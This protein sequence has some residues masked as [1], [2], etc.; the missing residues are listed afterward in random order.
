LR[1]EAS[2]LAALGVALSALVSGCTGELKGEAI[3]GGGATT[4]TTGGS[5]SA[6]TAGTTAGTG[7]SGTSGGGGTTSTGGTGSGANAGSGGMIDPD[8]PTPPPPAN[9]GMVTARRLN[10]IEYNNT[11]HD[12]LG[13][14]MRPA[15]TFQADGIGAGF[16]TV[17]GA[18]SMS[19]TAVRDYEDAAYELVDELIADTARYSMIV[20]CDVTVQGEACMRTALEGLARKAYRRPVTT[21][22]ID[23]LLTPYRTAIML[24][25]APTLGL[26]YSLAAVLVNQNFLFKLEIDPDPMSVTPRRLNDYEIATRLSYAL[27]STMPDA[28]LFAAAEAGTLQ[29]DAELTRQVDRMLADTR[30]AAFSANFAGQWLEFRDTNHDPDTR[31][32]PMYTP[33]LAASMKQEAERFFA[34]FMASETP[35]SQLLSARFTYVDTGLANHYGLPVQTGMQPGQMWRADTT[36]AE[37]SGLLTLGAVLT[38]TSLTTRTSPVKRGEFVLRRLMCQTVMQPPPDVIGIPDE[39]D[40]NQGQLTMR[41]R[42]EQHRNN[43]ACIGCHLDMDQL[44][45]GLENYDAVG[46]YRTTDNNLPVDSAGELP[47]GSTF[48]G[49][50]ELAELLSRDSRFN[51]CLARNIMTYALGRYLDQR[52][53]QTWVAYVAG[54][55]RD[56]GGKLGTLIRTL[57]KSES[58]RSRQAIVAP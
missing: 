53:D 33:A 32:F 55:T 10:R 54:T 4:S 56:Q 47:D 9:P 13:T 21:A 22:E 31:V 45:F 19:P 23:T 36:G 58:F 37:R 1:L 29:T 40:P 42:M 8:A 50:V 52:D 24:G 7:T 14:S 30:A 48:T 20:P 26:R 35:A 51:T 17:G 57:L 27:W 25:A 15:D 44:G 49:A 11:V 46:K 43:D 16:D 18:L 41:Q 3:E 38:A 34:D 2:A 6:G 39:V 28:E 12:L 5:S